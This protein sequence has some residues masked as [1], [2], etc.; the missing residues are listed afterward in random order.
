MRKNKFPGVPGIHIGLDVCQ[1]RLQS[2][3]PISISGRGG[4]WS[5]TWK[6]EEKMSLWGP[7]T[8]NPYAP[9]STH[10]PWCNILA[11]LNALA[12]VYCIHERYCPP[13][14]LRHPTEYFDTHTHTTHYIMCSTCSMYLSQHTFH[15]VTFSPL[16]FNAC[17]CVYYIHESYFLFPAPST[18]SHY[19]N[20]SMRQWRIW[21]MVSRSP[22]QTWNR[23]SFQKV[24]WSAVFEAAENI[25][26]SLV[27]NLVFSLWLA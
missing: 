8:R 10:V 11:L 27:K 12:C 14:P 23:T 26:R 20:P 13:S 1:Q 19:L 15:D 21:N 24:T 25:F 18:P 3:L 4:Q 2:R 9:H 7:N 17:V 6:N 16:F 22:T 5:Q